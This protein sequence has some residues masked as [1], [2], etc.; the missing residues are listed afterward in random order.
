MTKHGTAVSD[1]VMH[2]WVRACAIDRGRDVSL[3]RRDRGA[4]ERAGEQR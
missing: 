3:S 1:H 2:L 4:Y